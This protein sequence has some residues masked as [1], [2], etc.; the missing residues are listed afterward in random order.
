MLDK[1]E[2][3][4]IGESD[5]E[6]TFSKIYQFVG[7]SEGLP[8]FTTDDGDVMVITEER[9]RKEFLKA[10]FINKIEVVDEEIVSVEEK[11]PKHVGLRYNSGKPRFDLVHPWSHEQ[12]VNVLTVGANKY[13]DRNWEDGMAWSNVIASLKRHLNAIEAGEDLSLIHI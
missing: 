1:K 4:Y 11:K 5:E 8:S 10:G 6:F 2:Y 3:L 12:M 13:H 7:T 9:M